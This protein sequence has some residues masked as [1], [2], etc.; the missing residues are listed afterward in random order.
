MTQPLF[1]DDPYLRDAPAVVK[2]LTEEGGII[3]DRSVF[4]PTSGGQP[5][6][7]GWLNWDGQSMPVATAIRGQGEDIILVPSE[8]MALPPLGAHVTQ[9]LDWDRRHRHMRL[10]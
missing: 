6:D 2:A 9:V 10:T 4:Y 8:A 5:G 7:S 1:L 3:L